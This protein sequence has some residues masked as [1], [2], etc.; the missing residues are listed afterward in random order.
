MTQQEFAAVLADRPPKLPQK[1]YWI[2]SA[3]LRFS[4]RILTITRLWIQR[5]D[6][7]HTLGEL[8]SQMLKD[9]GLTQT[10]ARKEARKPFWRA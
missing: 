3:H 4:R 1:I 10:A 6:Q 5:I 2:R 8:E 9:L 7:R